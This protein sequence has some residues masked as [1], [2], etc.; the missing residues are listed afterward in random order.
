[1]TVRLL[2]L[3]GLPEVTA[4]TDLAALVAAHTVLEDGDVVVIAQKAVSKAEGAVVAIGD[5]PPAAARE[6]LARA[7][8]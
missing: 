7:T 1:M 3:S 4:G 5:E 8:A 2:G 6:R